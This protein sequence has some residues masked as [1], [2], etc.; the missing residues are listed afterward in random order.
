MWSR[1]DEYISEEKVRRAVMHLKDR[2]DGW[3]VR[4]KSGNETEFMLI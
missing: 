2:K 4:L 3:D 1:Y